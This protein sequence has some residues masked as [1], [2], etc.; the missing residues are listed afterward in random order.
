MANGKLGAWYVVTQLEV[1][2]AAVEASP[3]DVPVVVTRAA[4]RV[5]PTAM[6]LGML[7][8]GPPGVG[9]VGGACA[10]AVA[11][12]LQVLSALADRVVG[13]AAGVA[14]PL[15]TGQ[16]RVGDAACH[17]D[18]GLGT[19]REGECSLLASL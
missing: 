17:A 7:F 13:L 10:G 19:P 4:A 15:G 8:M 12:R 5:P 18:P 2:D 1:G 11:A 14:P 16:L 6:S 9:L 3:T